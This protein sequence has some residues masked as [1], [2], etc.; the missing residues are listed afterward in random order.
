MAGLKE[1][2]RRITSVKNTRQITRAMKLVSAAK[3]RRAQE[4]ADHG[5]RFLDSFE[6]DLNYLLLEAGEQYENTLLKHR[7]V[8]KN[9]L[10]ICIA[11]ERGLCGPYNSNVFRMLQANEQKADVDTRFILIGRRSVA[12]GK[13]LG[14]N[15]LRG[16]EGIGEDPSSWPLQEIVQDCAGEFQSGRIDEVV[17]YYTRFYTAISQR[18]VREVLLPLSLEPEG[19]PSGIEQ[20]LQFSPLPAEH[21]DRA[22][23][24]Y[25]LACLKQAA[26]DAKASE[27]AARMTAM[28]SATN[29]ANEL[30]DKLMLYYNR[31]RQT[32]ITS[33]LL[34]VLGGAE[35]VD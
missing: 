31:A 18:A 4:T 20:R 21:L 16:I 1:I 33:E 19:E 24:R 7:Q 28:D 3:L 26:F 13:R 32:A 17:L 10:V 29:N 30:L 27:H 12:A 5:R 34:D 35:A 14:L 6:E 22:L 25:L 23:P 2:R 11:G 8:V 9:R 15:T